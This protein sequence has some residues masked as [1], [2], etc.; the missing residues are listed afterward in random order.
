MRHGITGD[1]SVGDC[2]ERLVIRSSMNRT[3]STH[4][5]HGNPVD[6]GAGD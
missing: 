5:R 4:M 3:V 1:A 6:G 2:G